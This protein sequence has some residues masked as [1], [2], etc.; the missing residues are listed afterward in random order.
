MDKIIKK[1]IGSF[2][3]LSILLLIALGTAGGPPNSYMSAVYL[4]DSFVEKDIKKIQD[5]TIPDLGMEMVWVGPGKSTMGS[6]Q[7]DADR[8]DNERP[9][10]VTLTQGFWLGRYEVTTGDFK[11][12]VEATGHRAHSEM[13]NALY[14]SVTGEG[15]H[16]KNWRNIFDGD[17]SKP[18]IGISKYDAY[19]FCQWLTEREHKAGRLPE[20]YI[21]TLPTEA[22]WEYACRAGSSTRFSFGDNHDLL[23]RYANYADRTIKGKDRDHDDGYR[24]A[25]PVGSFRPNQWGF[26][27]MHGNVY[28]LCADTY[29]GEYQDG[30]AIDP[31]GPSGARR[32]VYLVRG[33]AWSSAPR[34]TRSA[35]RRAVPAKDSYCDVGFRIVLRRKYSAI[36][37][38]LTGVNRD[39]SLLRK[40]NTSRISYKRLSS[41][42]IFNVIH[43]PDRRSLGFPKARIREEKMLWVDLPV[44]ASGRLEVPEG[45]EVKLHVNKVNI[46]SD[47]DLAPL[48]SLKP[49]DLQA[50]EISGEKMGSAA[51]RH[52]ANLTG[53]REVEIDSRRVRDSGLRHLSGLMHLEELDLSGTKVRGPGLDYLNRYNRLHRLALSGTKLNNE[54]LEHLTRFKQLRVLK[55]DSTGIGE[56]GSH[57][58]LNPLSRLK[59]LRELDLSHTPVSNPE[60][61]HLSKLRNLEYLRLED[62]PITSAGLNYLS[63]LRNLKGLDLR[64]TEVDNDG[65]AYLSKLTNMERLSVGEMWV[66]PHDS[67]DDSGRISWDEGKGLITDE[68]LR[69]LSEMKNLHSLT[70]DKTNITGKGFSYLTGL[71]DLRYLWLKDSSVNDAGL[72]HIARLKGLEV[73]DISG[74]MVTDAGLNHLLSM[75]NLKE[76]VVIGTQVTKRGAGNFMGQRKDVE[77]ILEE[78]LDAGFQN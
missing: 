60:L 74:N 27:D 48:E 15:I 55:L 8:Y 66:P 75:P 37:F 12:F 9:H 46:K 24:Y 63:N 11:R 1:N 26:Y 10:D 21:F 31:L 64:K 62:T 52:I 32:D 49:D 43:F 38:T 17:S 47:V 53:L 40:G 70:I 61:V 30:V 36:L 42:E 2:A 25:A 73:V 33:G 69:H 78:S 20:A 44:R 29:W 6:P 67:Y 34:D 65:L 68:G 72:A 50:I 4:E 13:A 51:L 19:S 77:V 23:Y 57:G 22:Q 54:G 39:W 5:F 14:N 59:E 41:E 18:V 71:K 45:V 3:G 35:V 16:G 56:D 58:Y 7:S 76:V 28:E